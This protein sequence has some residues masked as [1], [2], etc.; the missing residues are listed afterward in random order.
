ME[1]RRTD[2][3]PDCATE[4]DFTKDILEKRKRGKGTKAPVSVSWHEGIKG[5]LS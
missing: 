3:N 4:E 2:T 1:T 5:Y